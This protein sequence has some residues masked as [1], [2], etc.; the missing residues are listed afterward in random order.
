MIRARRVV[1][2]T[3]PVVATQSPSTMKYGG[4]ERIAYLYGAAFQ[5]L[6]HRV[7]PVA[8]SDSSFSHPIEKSWRW[9]QESLSRDLREQAAYSEDI[10][11]ALRDYARFVAEVVEQEQPDVVLAL[12]PAVEI[13][14]A[15]ETRCPEFLERFVVSFR[16]G[17]GDISTELLE[18][19]DRYPSIVLTALTGIHLESLQLGFRERGF[20]GV[21]DRV[22]LVTD[23]VLVEAFD[24]VTDP[25]SVR[26]KPEWQLLGI[27]EDTTRRIVSQI[28]YFSPN[29]GQL[30][31]L[32]MFARAN[33]KEQGYSLVLAGGYGWQLPSRDHDPDA[34]IALAE[35]YMEHLQKRANE[36]NVMQH[37]HVLPALRGAE[38]EMLY[39]ASDFTI[40]PVRFDHGDLWP[41]T[42]NQDKEAHGLAVGLAN[43]TGTPVLVSSQVEAARVTSGVNGFQFSTLTEGISQASHLAQL[44]KEGM[45]DRAAVRAHAERRDSIAPAIRAYLQIFESLCGNEDQGLEADRL[46]AALRE[47]ARGEQASSQAWFAAAMS[48]ETVSIIESIDIRHSSTSESGQFQS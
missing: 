47:V 19:L 11:C 24:L 9:P 7:I 48:D 12:G 35:R 36:L 26:K 18:I 33:L 28:D 14:Q 2:T 25:G 44:C 45:I 27:P 32:E 39:G 46:K 41:G 21:A 30:L 43:A 22:R 6:G 1:I 29:K 3:N 38:V 17:P 31:S 20:D 8:S 13:L 40:V 37:V 15:L 23:G 5:Q 16:N 4:V 10:P 34:S 42:E